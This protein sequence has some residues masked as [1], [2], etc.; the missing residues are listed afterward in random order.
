M[1]WQWVAYG[2]A[3]ASQYKERKKERKKERNRGRFRFFIFGHLKIS[4]LILCCGKIAIEL[5]K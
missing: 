4:P 1:G 3:M 2:V 5:R